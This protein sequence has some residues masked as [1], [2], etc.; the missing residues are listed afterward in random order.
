M[1]IT[2]IH[3]LFVTIAPYATIVAF[4]VMIYEIVKTK[5]IAKDAKEIAEKTGK[6]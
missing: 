4:M 3:N 5:R 6:Q 2:S 1:S